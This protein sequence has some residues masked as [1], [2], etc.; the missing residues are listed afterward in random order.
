MNSF[1]HDL[2]EVRKLRATGRMRDSDD[3]G[4]IMARLSQRLRRH[5]ESTTGVE[6]P[7]LKK[8]FNPPVTTPDYKAPL[9][10]VGNRTDK[11]K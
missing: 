7:K 9:S 4:E 11:S 10:N 6:Q 2:A 1:R 8:Q 5:L 3:A